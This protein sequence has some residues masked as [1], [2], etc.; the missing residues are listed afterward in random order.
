MKATNRVFSSCPAYCTLVPIH[1]RISSF[2]SLHGPFGQP[3]AYVGL[4]IYQNT[5]SP[6]SNEGL[7]HL[8]ADVECR[9]QT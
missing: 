4:P 3:K 2:N 1:L 8:R 7:I 9:S 6:G 5:V